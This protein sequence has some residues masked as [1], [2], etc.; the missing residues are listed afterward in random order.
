M[1]RPL[2]LI[3]AS[4]AGIGFFLPY[5]T[6]PALFGMKISRSGAQVGGTLWLVLVAVTAIL[7][8]QL[9]LA[10]PSRSKEVRNATV[11][12][13]IL[14]LGALLLGAFS[15]VSGDNLF[16]ISAADMGFRPG[17]GAF[18]S[19]VGLVLALI[20]AVRD[21]EGTWPVAVRAGGFPGATTALSGGEQVS[22]AVVQK[23]RTA[24]REYDIGRL[25]RDT[26]A[27]MQDSFA[28]FHRW[29]QS[30]HVREKARR[31]APAAGVA[32][33]GVVLFSGV[34]YG[35]VKPRP[36]S[37]GLS[38][39]S[40]FAGCRKSYEDR[41]ARVH[42]TFLSG[43]AAQHHE[44]RSAARGA[45]EALLG[46]ERPTYEACIQSAEDQYSRLVS[47]YSDHEDVQE[48][49]TAFSAGGG[50]RNSAIDIEQSSAGRA[51]VEDKIL[52]IR[53]SVPDSAVIVQNLT[54][55]RM[56]QW[57]F[58]YAS[59]IKRVQ[60]VSQRLDGNT[61]ILRTNL[62]LEDYITRERYYAILDLNYEMNDDGAWNYKGFTELVYAR[63]GERY[64]VNGN[65]FIVGNWRWKNNYATYNPDGSWFGRW[66]DGSTTTGMWKIVAGRLVLTRNGSG[67]VDTPIRQFSASELFVGNSG[68]EERAER[69]H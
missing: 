35:F 32:M 8:V 21:R 33:A 58:S 24:G 40:A 37:D 64:E 67:W 69:I 27:G 55:Q 42:T 13:S 38:A 51:E 47:R 3:G 20:G 49:L 39:A 34:Y 26:V 52:A 50:Q 6:S 54:G 45:L 15:L 1:K 16:G 56:Q 31:H 66:D 9:L 14:G 19:A 59:E 7:G 57:R 4:I 29:L 63:E 36:D 28:R 60:V 23:E 5:V 46:A 48:F 12:A 10:D 53:A 62:S 68:Q 11:A 18:A 61:L 2:V 43:F 65:L 25:S 22:D 41:V 44:R 17:I 30:R